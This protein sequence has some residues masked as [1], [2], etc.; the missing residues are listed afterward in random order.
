MILK[1]KEWLSSLISE[2]K[3][4]LCVGLD[5]DI[6]KF[7]DCVLGQADPIFEFNR[8]IID[9]TKEYCVAFKLNIA[10][11]ESL[12]MSG[13][14][15]LQKTLDYIP[16]N[17][18]VIA[19]AK[20]GDIGNTSQHYAKTFFETFEC[21]GITVNPYMGKDSVAPFLE[22]KNKWSILLA[23][24][25]NAGSSDIQQLQTK[26][27]SMVFENVLKTSQS[28][29]SIDQ[30]MYV[31]GA[32]KAS[33]LQSIR[34]IVP[35]HFL[36]IPGVG[37]QGGQ[38]GEV[39]ENGMCDGVGLLINSSRSIIFASHGNDFGKAAGIEAKKLQAEM[40]QLLG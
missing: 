2:K 40:Q 14:H 10:F 28:W 12:G 38:V 23:L 15:S 31:V 20:R 17:H 19:D 36:L 26:D 6:S 8:Q 35:D 4:V 30:I 27:G 7:P 22:Y 16:K 18:L 32:T 13:W 39:M 24:T 21:D 25:S 9:Y 5:S 34:A 1:N 11:Y 3:S 37:A 33:Q 29:G